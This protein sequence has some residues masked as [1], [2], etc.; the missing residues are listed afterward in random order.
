M[1]I[2]VDQ[3]GPILLLPVP[4][5]P[6]SPPHLHFCARRGKGRPGAAA[7]NRGAE[8]RCPSLGMSC[9]PASFPPSRGEPTARQGWR[10][11][12]ALRRSPR[13]PPA[14]RS[15][16]RRVELRPSTSLSRRRRL[17]RGPCGCLPPRRC[18]PSTTTTTWKCSARYRR[19]GNGDRA[20]S[21]APGCSRGAPQPL[22]CL[23]GGLGVIEGAHLGP[24][25]PR[26]LPFAPRDQKDAQQQDGAK[27]DC[28]FQGDRRGGGCDRRAGTQGVG[29]GG[30]K[31]AAAAGRAREVCKALLIL[32]AV[33]A[34]CC[35]TE[36][37]G[38][39]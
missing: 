32:V 25:P 38:F 35:E 37:G 30:R 1:P 36:V 22:H 29:L 17:A 6:P 23:F 11:S 2:H 21:L 18:W 33:W 27:L 39:T 20:H 10:L 31:A 3:P 34:S 24:G 19:R 8:G 14:F 9:L 13:P 5:P 12:A 26:Q 28:H 15:P 4:P 16:A 7:T